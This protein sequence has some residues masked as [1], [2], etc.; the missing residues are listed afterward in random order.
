MIR[1][2]HSNVVLEDIVITL[3]PWERTAVL[4]TC[5]SYVTIR[6]C[7][8]KRQTWTEWIKGVL[9]GFRKRT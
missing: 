8:F 9:N 1:I 5:N 4:A 6:S 3:K 7:V 2:N